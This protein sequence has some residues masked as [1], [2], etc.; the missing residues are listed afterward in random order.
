MRLL[1]SILV[2]FIFSI[3]GFSQ[4]YLLDED[5]NKDTIIPNIGFKRKFQLAN[6]SGFAWAAGP[7]LGTPPSSIDYL[8]SWQFREGFWGRIKLNK[9][10]ALGSYIEYA[11]DGYNMKSPLIVDTFNNSKTLWTKQV[12]NNAVLGFFNRVYLKK[13]K[14]YLDIGGYYAFDFLPRILT[15][16]KPANG[17]FQ[18][19]RTIY[20]RPSF[21]NRSHYGIDIRLNYGALGI[22]GR[23]RITGLYKNT[24][25]DLPKMMIGIVIDYKD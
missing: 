22:Y 17:D 9:W 13:D 3:D 18:Y 25:Y 24:D 11:R 5:V 20:N 2:L 6:Y 1:F 14:I 7:H 8:K 19:K 15:K 10:Y 16:I 23:Y 21:M 4:K 12:N